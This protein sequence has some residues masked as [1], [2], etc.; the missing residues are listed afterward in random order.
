MVRRISFAV[1]VAISSTEVVALTTSA[2]LRWAQQAPV[3]VSRPVTT[4]GLSPITPVSYRS[5]RRENLTVRGVHHYTHHD[6]VVL[7]DRQGEP[8]SIPQAERYSS[9]DWLHN[10][11]TLPS[12]II[13]NRIKIPVAAQM[14][15]ALLIVLIHRIRPVA[16]SIKPHTL[17]GS[18]LGLLLVF[19]TNAAYTRF[20][21]GRQIWQVLL[22]CS[23]DLA[24]MSV[25]YND[26]IGRK[27]ILRIAQL[28]C[29]FPHILREHLQ[30]C[31][32]SG[33]YEK[34]LSPDELS[35][36]STTN[37]NRPL[38]IVNTLSKEIMKVSYGIN[39]TS[40]ERLSMLDKVNK[41]SSCIG[42]CER[43]VQTPVPLH[44]VRHTSRFLTIWCFMLPLVLVSEMAW[45]TI[46]IAGLS[47]W[48]LFGIQEIGLLI[49][50]PFQRSLRL[51][52]FA[53]TVYSDVMQTI[54][55]E[56]PATP[57][58]PIPTSEQASVLYAMSSL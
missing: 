39:W 24:R 28:L 4:S 53:D 49:E 23:R 37:C 52:V 21:E 8:L 31:R 25:L 50:E 5:R 1:L 43:L 30:G 13:L 38:L 42:S 29:V 15:W 14:G 33:V 54:G 12:S 45:M 22:D 2:P 47:T 10:I 58:T 46:P 6:E 9:R 34:L 19:R 18:A 48:A 41:L 57:Q 44:Y 26:V 17:L 56:S 55:V 40:R 51:E 36:L 27:L 7:R 32:D 11:I 20:W 16:I 3:V 35:I